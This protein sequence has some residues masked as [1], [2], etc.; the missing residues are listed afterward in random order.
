MERINPDFDPELAAKREAEISEQNLK[1]EEKKKKEML[2]LYLSSGSTEEKKGKKRSMRKVA[3]ERVVREVKAMQQQMS[4]K[5]ESSEKATES[6]DSCGEDGSKNV[7]VADV[8]SPKVGKQ[9]QG[10]TVEVR[11]GMKNKEK[12]VT[13]KGSDLSRRVMGEENKMVS[14][15]VEKKKVPITKNIAMRRRE[16]MSKGEGTMKKEA[17]SKKADKSKNA[18]LTKEQKKKDHV[19]KD[20]HTLKELDIDLEHPDANSYIVGK[21][22]TFR[23]LLRTSQCV[24]D[25]EGPD[26][27]NPVVLSYEVSLHCMSRDSKEI[28]KLDMWKIPKTGNDIKVHVQKYSAYMHACTLSSHS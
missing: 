10:V 7:S 18:P 19:T 1:E 9:R 6:P 25:G 13:V 27:N 20:D 23:A 4:V 14:S 5:E 8:P 28:R 11:M 15:E 26:S 3:R 16:M 24:P 22:D 21:T 12:D 2:D 17:T